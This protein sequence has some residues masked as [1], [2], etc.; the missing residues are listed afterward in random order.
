MKKIAFI[1]FLLVTAQAMA[2]PSRKEKPYDGKTQ[3][4][5]IYSDWKGWVDERVYN[6][7][8]YELYAMPGVGY[9]Q[10]Q[11]AGKDSLGTYSGMFVEYLIWSKSHQNNKF[12]PSHVKVYTKFNLNKSTHAEMGRM[13]MYS[14]GVQLS[15][16][17]NPRRTFL[18]PFFGTEIGGISQKQLGTAFT[19][20]PIIGIYAL[21]NKNVY[22]NFYAGY[23]YPVKKFDYLSGYSLQASI[24]FALW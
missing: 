2:Q 15:I 10:Y 19:L 17:K 3:N 14:A 4:D 23:L 12:G 8:N 16:E 13:Y 11:F 9:V 6:K 18:I 21:A 20:H 22:L 7:Y 5:S 24:N 1:I